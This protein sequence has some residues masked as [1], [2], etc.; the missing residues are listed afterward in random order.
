MAYLYHCCMSVPLSCAMNLGDVDSNCHFGHTFVI[1][2]DPPGSFCH[3]AVLASGTEG[4]FAGKQSF[5][6][7]L[8]VCQLLYAVKRQVPKAIMPMQQLVLRVQ[9]LWFLVLKDDMSERAIMVACGVVTI[10]LL[11]VLITSS[12]LFSDGGGGSTESLG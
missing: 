12:V 9:R 11:S 7:L 2:L 6:Q 4:C 5:G 1:S 3:L 8:L 10:A